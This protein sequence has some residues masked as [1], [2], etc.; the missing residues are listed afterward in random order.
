MI[1]Y[2]DPSRPINFEWRRPAEAEITGFG[3]RQGKT[4]DPKKRDHGYQSLPFREML[5]SFTISYHTQ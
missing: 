2:Y 4:R 3:D 1:E 5:S